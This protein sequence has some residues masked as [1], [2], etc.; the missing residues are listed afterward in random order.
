MHLISVIFYIFSPNR[1]LYCCVLY[2]NCI[3]FQIQWSAFIALSHTITFCFSH[4]LSN[5]FICTPCQINP[6]TSQ[7]LF[8]F[9][10]Q[11]Y[12]LQIGLPQRSVPHLFFS[13]VTIFFALTYISHTT[14]HVNIEQP[15]WQHTSLTHTHLSIHKH[16]IFIKTWFLQVNALSHCLSLGL[17]MN[18]F[19][20]QLCHITSPCL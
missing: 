12:H 11:Q 2:P 19:N 10:Q 18:P 8:N 1:K 17:P 9:C 15:W 3:V 6:L 20:Q 14:T 13:L 4:L 16:N 7:H 5:F